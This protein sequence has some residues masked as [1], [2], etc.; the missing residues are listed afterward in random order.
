MIT[1][2]ELIQQLSQYPDDMEVFD[3]G[4]MEIENVRETTWTRNNYPYDKPDKQILVID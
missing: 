1:V 2:K 4:L 3:V